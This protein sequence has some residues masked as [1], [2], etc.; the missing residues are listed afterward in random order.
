MKIVL[1][2]DWFIGKDVL[3]D[4]FSFFVLF[5]FL[6]LAVKNYRLSKNRSLLYLG[7]GFGMVALAQLATI[8]T[9]LV[10]YYNFGP[11]QAIGNALIT[12]QLVSSVDIFYYA[13]FFFHRLMT[14]L[15]FFIIYRLPRE[16]KSWGDYAL[17]LYFIFV[18]ALLSKEMYYLFH[19]TALVLLVLIVGNYYGVLMK[20]GL[21][22][23]KILIVAFSLLAFSQLVFALSTLD[24]MFVLANIIELVSYSI[25][26]GLGIRLLQHGKEKKPNGYN[27]GYVGDNSGKKRKH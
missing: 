23:T 20:H 4:V 24:L 17:V 26:L 12:S 14:L 6:I 15:G 21:F 18:S 13:G 7:V 5:V 27:I 16:K 19:L 8:F 3:I 22:N 1:T 10:L 2:P 25:L 11:T 9:K